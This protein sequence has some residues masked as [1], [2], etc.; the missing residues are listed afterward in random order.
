MLVSPPTHS[1][2]SGWL[3]SDMI[4]RSQVYLLLTFLQM[5]DQLDL[6]FLSG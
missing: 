1:N 2:K 4:T 3:F 5:S 6:H